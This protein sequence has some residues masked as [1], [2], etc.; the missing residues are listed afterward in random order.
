M[1]IVSYF[2]EILFFNCNTHDSDL[3][4]GEN[5]RKWTS[6]IIETTPSLFHWYKEPGGTGC[7][8]KGSLCG[9]QNQKEIKNVG[10]WRYRP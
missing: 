1:Y 6:T 3:F 10:S 9:L 4:A 7:S 2:V 8:R 5:K